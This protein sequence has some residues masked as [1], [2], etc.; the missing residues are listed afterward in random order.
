MTA[1]EMSADE[2]AALVRPV[3]GVGF[4]IITGTPVAMLRA[5]SK[6]DDWV[7]LT[8]SGG[9]SL[10]IHEVFSHPNVHYRVSFYGGNERALA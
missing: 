5:L 2:A 10:G 3:D 6:R 4:G 8:F 9:L 7:D 1:R